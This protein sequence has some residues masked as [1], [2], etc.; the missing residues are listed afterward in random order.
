MT[1][2]ERR[3]PV[4]GHGDLSAEAARPG[5]NPI[6]MSVLSTTLN[7]LIDEKALSASVAR[8]LRE[9]E[10]LNAMSDNELALLGISRDEV[11]EYVLD[12]QM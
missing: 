2:M 12:R 4:Q 10:A 3:I 5:A 8:H 9:I 6:F 11:T 1:H 7:W